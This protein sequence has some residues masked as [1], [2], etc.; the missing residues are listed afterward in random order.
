[1]AKASSKDRPLTATCPWCSA[2]IAEDATVCPSCG[3]SLI[4]DGDPDVPG[5][6]TI[7]A[8]PI[9]TG[10][11][12][13][14][15]RSRLLAWISGEYPT[16]TPSKAEVQAIA[17]PDHE[18]RREMRR[19]ELEA[20]VARL[21]AEANAIRADAAEPEGTIDEPEAVPP[22]DAE[23]AAADEPEADGE[24]AVEDRPPA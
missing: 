8:K 10:K 5:V 14:Q 2:A 12:T 1:M 11:A 9:V 7:A 21:Q 17:P 15:P 18:V 13:S 4:S 3:A 23:A 6:T 20:E 19:L 16:D 22:G 24:S